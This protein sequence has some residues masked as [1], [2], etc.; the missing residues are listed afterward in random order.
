MLDIKNNNIFLNFLPKNPI[1]KNR[2]ATSHFNFLPLFKPVFLTQLEIR[3][4]ALSYD[5]PFEILI[6]PEKYFPRRWTI[7]PTCHIANR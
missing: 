3:E 6:R 7:F 4:F 1:D 2:K 5:Q